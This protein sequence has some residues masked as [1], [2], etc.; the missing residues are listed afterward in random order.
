EDSAGDVEPLEKPDRPRTLARIEA[1]R[2]RRVGELADT[3]ARQPVVHE[4]RDQE[5]VLGDPQSWIL[6]RC[7]R[8]ELENRV[9]RDQLDAGP[10]VPLAA[11]YAGEDAV[12]GARPPRVAVVARVL[13]Q[14]APAIEQPEV[15][16]PGVD[17]DGVDLA[18]R[19]A[20]RSQ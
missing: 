10:L 3:G 8:R 7:H 12:D 9:D 14:P 5:Q 13:D 2:G 18:A 1:L 19:C 4:V 20:S 15:D 17:A 6:V 11:R 16:R